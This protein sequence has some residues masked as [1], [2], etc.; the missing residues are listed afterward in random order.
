MSDASAA[1][2]FV[3]ERLALGADRRCDCD[4]HDARREQATPAQADRGPGGSFPQLTAS[5][6][7]LDRPPPD[8]AEPD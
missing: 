3:P 7:E 6:E 4:Q 1:A 2:F 5:F 8:H